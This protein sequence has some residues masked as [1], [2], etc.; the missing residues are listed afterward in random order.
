MSGTMILKLRCSKLGAIANE[1]RLSGVM[2]IRRLRRG[3]EY[4]S[5][6]S[7]WQPSCV[8]RHGPEIAVQHESA[9]RHSAACCH[10]I[11]H[12]SHRSRHPTRPSRRAVGGCAAP[13]VEPAAAHAKHPAHQTDRVIGD[14]GGEE[15]KLGVHVFAAHC[16]KK[17]DALRITSFS[18]LT[19]F[20]S[21][22]S[23]ANSAASA[24]V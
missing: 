5:V 11:S 19:R 23:C 22:R 7:A 17:A 4:C 24:F 2:G 13:G 20:T 14:V 6:S 10:R 15:R 1:W 18:C 3:G 21:R 12:G 9:A 16:A 8:T